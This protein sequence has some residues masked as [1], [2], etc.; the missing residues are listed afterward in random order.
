MA[1]VRRGCC[2]CSSALRCARYGKSCV[3]CARGLHVRS[4]ARLSRKSAREGDEMFFRP[5]TESA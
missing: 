4:M 1:R 3:R 2:W 5:E